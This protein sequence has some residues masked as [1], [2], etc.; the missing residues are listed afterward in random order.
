MA[1][2][3]TV[4]FQAWAKREGLKGFHQQ[5]PERL[6]SQYVEHREHECLRGLENGEYKLPPSQDPKELIALGY[7][8]SPGFFVDKSERKEVSAAQWAKMP[9]EEQVDYLRWICDMRRVN[10]RVKGRKCRM[11]GLAGMSHMGVKGVHTH[12]STEDVK[13]AY[14]RVGVRPDFQKV[15]CVDLGSAVKSCPR[16]VVYC[17]LPMG[18]CLSPYVFTRVMKR[19]V[20]II[21]SPHPDPADA[22]VTRPGIPT[23]VWLDDLLH[24]HRGKEEGKKDQ[25]FIDQVLKD[26]FG[27]DARH[28]RK[29]EGWGPDGPVT[30]VKRHLGSALDME[31]GLF[32]TTPTM[33]KR[34]KQTAKAILRSLARHARWVG[35]RWIAEFAGAAISTHLSNNQARFRCRAFHDFL[36]ECDVHHKGYEVRGKVGREVIQALEWWRDL[37]ENRKVRRAIWRDPVSEVYA[38]DASKRGHGALDCPGIA[39]LSRLPLGQEMGVPTLGLWSLEESQTHITRLELRAVEEKLKLEGSR[40]DRRERIEGRTLLIWEDNAAVVGILNSLSTKA[41]SLYPIL[42]R[43]VGWLDYL[44][45][46]LICRYIESAE[47]PADWFSRSAD[48]ADWRFADHVLRRLRLLS[49]WGEVTVDRFADR[50]NAVCTR[51]NSAFPCLGTEAIDAFTQ[52]W[53]GEINFVN[54][55]WSKLH[56]AV[57]K[58]AVETD[59]AA[60]VLA[61]RWPT[62]EWWPLLQEMAVESVVVHDPKDPNNTLDARDFLVGEFLAQVERLPEPLR[63][64]G[65]RIDAYW[66]PFRGPGPAAIV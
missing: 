25:V 59:A 27:Q 55:P 24:M 40:Q 46:T 29:G 32:L 39:H 38:L 28:P 23:V 54:P 42:E 16:F 58:L 50:K 17:T 48:K 30:Y 19:P 51:F 4:P 52:R 12:V 34:L 20:S 63:N 60:V 22:T 7:M 66:V 8:I 10:M 31:R 37:G 18:Y 41:K 56:L 45:L 13:G 36:V 21:R 3:V 47:N 49:R 44:D 61:P 14:K 53:S 64:Q 9:V 5:M 11:K 62:A 33:V 35:A 26:H 65:W 15:F 43:I 2:G 1:E 57:H 6:N